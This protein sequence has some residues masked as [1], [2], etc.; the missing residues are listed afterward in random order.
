MEAFKANYD[1]I[2]SGDFAVSLIEASGKS[3]EFAAIKETAKNRIFNA[4]RKT[5]LEVFGR[6]VVH[7]ALDGLL[8]LL[9]ELRDAKWK[10]DKLSAYHVQLARALAFPL[11]P[12]RPTPMTRSTP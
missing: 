8:P 9:D 1:E 3:K 6:N 4:R 7:S 10:S 11:R 2:M 5:E 12:A